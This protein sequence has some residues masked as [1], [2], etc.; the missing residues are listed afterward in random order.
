MNLRSILSTKYFYTHRMV[1]HTILVALALSFLSLSSCSKPFEMDSPLFHQ[2]SLDTSLPIVYFRVSDFA[3]GNIAT[4]GTITATKGVVT[5]FSAPEVYLYLTEPATEDF[6][7]TVKINGSDVASKAYADQLADGMTYVTIPSSAVALEEAHVSFKKGAK[8]SDKPI[9]LKSASGYSD[10]VLAQL[11]NRRGLITLDLEA[12][13]K[14]RISRD[15]GQ[16][17]LPYLLQTE[18]LQATTENEI[19][20]LSPISGEEL[21]YQFVSVLDTETWSYPPIS[22]LY[23]NDLST[24]LFTDSEEDNQYFYIFPKNGGKVEV[25]GLYLSAP[26]SIAFDELTVYVS[27]DGSSWVSQGI[28]DLV[29]D[30]GNGKK[31]YYLFREPV[32]AAFFMIQPTT[33]NSKKK[34]G[35]S[36]LHLLK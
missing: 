9:K 18:N 30:T 25:K 6:T 8:K 15:Y 5:P 1:K 4:L 31:N 17:Y 35:F 12:S 27:F 22:N 14:V 3:I 7:L 29:P 19:Q 36:E 23:D 33:A 10:F 11:P 26:E 32:T 21:Q 28:I 20:N 34:F 16:F 2:E 13:D 24:S